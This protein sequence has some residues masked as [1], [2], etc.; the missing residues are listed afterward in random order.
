MRASKERAA[1]RVLTKEK[2][3]F[4]VFHSLIQSFPLP[5]SL[6]PSLSSVWLSTRRA[7][8]RLIR[9]GLRGR[10]EGINRC[11]DRVDAGHRPAGAICGFLFSLNSFAFPLPTTASNRR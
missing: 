2:K 9:C 7:G 1:K 4:Q 11:A 6:S 8:K 3:K 10:L 5:C